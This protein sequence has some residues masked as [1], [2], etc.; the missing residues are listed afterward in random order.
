MSEVQWLT[1]QAKHY[2]DFLKRLDGLELSY[3][4][5]GYKFCPVHE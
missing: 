5:L 3:S 1:P 2:D 4:H